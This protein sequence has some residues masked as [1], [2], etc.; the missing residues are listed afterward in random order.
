M[1][2][3][4]SSCNDKTEERFV[5]LPL[6][7]LGILGSGWQIQTC[8]V[9]SPLLA[10]VCTGLVSWISISLSSFSTVSTPR[11]LVGRD[12][13]DSSGVKGVLEL[14]VGLGALLS[15]RVETF[16]EVLR[17]VFLLTWKAD[18]DPCD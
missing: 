14:P 6:R 7:G 16:D 1:L 11:F 15:E 17:L 3:D 8:A 9:E 18:G 5:S 10:L 12:G 4:V 2:C 13:G